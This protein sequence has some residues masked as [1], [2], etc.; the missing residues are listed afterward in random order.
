MLGLA[1]VSIISSPQQAIAPIPKNPVKSREAIA[2]VPIVPSMNTLG[3]NLFRVR[4]RTNL[5]R[6]FEGK[7]D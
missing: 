3:L 7:N 6:V 1:F 4:R 2:V 5:L